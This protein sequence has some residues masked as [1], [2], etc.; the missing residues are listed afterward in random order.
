MHVRER[1]ATKGYVIFYDAVHDDAINVWRSIARQ[2]DGWFYDKMNDGFF[3]F[4]DDEANMTEEQVRIKVVVPDQDARGM[5][6]LLKRFYRTIFPDASAHNWHLIMSPAG[7]EDQPPRSE[8]L[9]VPLG[10]DIMDT[11]AL[12]GS[13]VVATNDDTCYNVYGW[14]ERLA[15]RSNRRLLELNKGDIFLFRG[16]FILAPVG[17]DSNNICLH[18]YLDSPFYERPHDHRPTVVTEIGDTR[19]IDDPSCIVENCTFEGTPLS[20]RRHLIRFHGIRFQR[21]ARL[22]EP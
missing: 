5:S 13:I 20:L 10:A 11:S 22:L 4:F 6:R 1:F 14:N 8:F 19:G 7:T 3:G 18:A 12:P 16:D 15:L 17:Y 9:T 2:T 21:A